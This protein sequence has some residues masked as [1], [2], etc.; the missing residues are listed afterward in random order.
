MIDIHT[1]GAGGGSLARVDSGGA[2]RVGPQ[3]AGAEPGPVCYGRGGIV[4][5]VT[6]ANLTLGRLSSADFL[7]G[8]MSLDVAAA[9]SALASLGRTMHADATTAALGA[10]R[11]ANA[12]MER[13][14][15][16]ISVERGYDPR[17]FTLVGFGG[18][19][20]LHA[21]ELAE[22][23]DMKSVLIPRHPGILCALG[24]LV[25]DL[26]HDVS[27]TVLMPLAHT[28][29]AVLADAFLPIM[30]SGIATMA[31]QDIAQSRISLELSMDMRYVGQSFEITV[32]VARVAAR[33]VSGGAKKWAVPDV[34]A[35]AARFHR[36]HRQRYGH[37]S[38]GEPVEVVNLRV[39]V[40]GRVDKPVFTPEP[41]QAPDASAA[42]MRSSAVVFAGS[43]SLATPVYERTLLRPGH[44]FAG[45]AIVVQMDA[46]T[47]IPPQWQ[48][49]V[50][51]YHNLILERR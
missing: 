4:P 41:E 47:V 33:S 10:V 18:A 44:R 50:D 22:A 23:L 5:T 36:Q 49:R 27:R 6:D 25:T 11:V 12:T 30:Q 48:A 20:P 43:E 19:G 42:I 32:P 35:I 21:C 51:G 8:R 26:T 45:P 14:I 34:Q 17:Q 37:A 28:S 7:G 39:K 1:V 2:L 16:T 13:A 9:Q 15:R 38:P 24:L 46:T 3:S 40:V 31:G 29:G